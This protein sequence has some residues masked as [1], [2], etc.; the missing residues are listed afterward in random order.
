MRFRV[1]KCPSRVLVM[2]TDVGP[3][4]KNSQKFQLTAMTDIQ[5]D[6]SADAR[7]LIICPICYA[8]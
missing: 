3:K 4:S 2:D 6:R 8:I 7:D 1:R 5:I